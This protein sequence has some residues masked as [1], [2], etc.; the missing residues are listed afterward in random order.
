M[1][2]RV[3]YSFSA[4]QL[5]YPP[6]HETNIRFRENSEC[7]RLFD[8]LPRHKSNQPL[9]P[10]HI[11]NTRV[12]VRISE[13]VKPLRSC[14]EYMTI[15]RFS[16]DD[17]SHW[18]R[19]GKRYQR[20][21]VGRIFFI[22]RVT[23][24]VR[25][26]LEPLSAAT[27][28]PSLVHRTCSAY[29]CTY[30]YRVRYTRRTATVRPCLSTFDERLSDWLS[31]DRSVDPSHLHTWYSSTHLLICL[32]VRSFIYLFIYLFIFLSVCLFVCSFVWLCISV[33]D[34]IERRIRTTCILIANQSP[35]R[36]ETYFRQ[37]LL[38]SPEFFSFS[39]FPFFTTY[40]HRV[41]R[42]HIFRV[43][44]LARPVTRQ[45]YQNNFSL[46]VLAVVRCCWFCQRSSVHFRQPL[47]LNRRRY[48]RCPF[49]YR[50]DY[51]LKIPISVTV[52]TVL[53]TPLSLLPIF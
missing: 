49:I 33:C 31:T 52:I 17:S 38:T 11:S 10:G 16:L 20:A 48:L 30:T 8:V 35:A 27:R 32:F 14:A 29:V 4:F 53:N 46:S 37:L 3:P 25:P 19:A 18:S 23:P 1:S 51:L 40:V 45:P 6:P 26:E 28:V 7:R 39:V 34:G 9:V 50:Y 21:S 22:P 2:H 43:I 15:R 44:R 47:P 41:I 13:P 24:L 12:H 36:D 5:P 42:V